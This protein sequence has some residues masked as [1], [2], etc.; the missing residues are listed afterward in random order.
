M[1][2][3]DIS[4]VHE[5]EGRKLCYVNEI[6]FLKYNTELLNSQVFG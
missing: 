3:S 6:P 5:E 4:K 1:G 2:E